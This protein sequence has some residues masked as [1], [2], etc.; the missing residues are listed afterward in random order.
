MEHK[1]KELA[2][3]ITHVHTRNLVQSH[4]VDLSLNEETRHLVI[5]VDNAGPMH[6]LS[7]D[8]GDHHLNSGLSEVYGDDITYEIK[9]AGGGLHEREKLVPHNINL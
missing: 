9:V 1:I 7:N 6:E 5:Y 8:E 3:A 4:V 2:E